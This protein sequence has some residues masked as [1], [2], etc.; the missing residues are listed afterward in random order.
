MKKNKAAALILCA[1]LCAAVTLSFLF[2]AVESDH[3][4]HMHL[5]E[6]DCPTCVEIHECLYF[7]KHITC[8][9]V[10]MAALIYCGLRALS[11]FRVLRSSYEPG[12]LVSLKIK[13]TN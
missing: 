8:I 11:Y 5:H 1:L 7:L 13:L 4:H 6:E 3:R 2:I 12:T 9:T 10:V